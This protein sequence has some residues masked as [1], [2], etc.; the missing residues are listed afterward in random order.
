[1]SLT[2]KKE[3]QKKKMSH[4]RAGSAGEEGGPDHDPQGNPQFAT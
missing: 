1:L 2:A 4:E 3:S